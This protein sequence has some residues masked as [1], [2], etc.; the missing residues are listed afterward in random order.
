MASLFPARLPDI[1]PGQMYFPEYTQM[2]EQQRAREEQEL[3]A[4]AAQYDALMGPNATGP[5]PVPATEAPA[6]DGVLVLGVG[7]ALLVV[8]FIAMSR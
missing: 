6:I 2:L 4:K 8:A 3:R 1:V 5:R 7:A